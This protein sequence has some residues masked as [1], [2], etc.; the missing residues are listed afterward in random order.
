MNIFFTSDHHFNHANIINYS[1]RPFQSVMDMDEIL[2]ERWNSVVSHKDVVYYVGDLT[3]GNYQFASTVLSMLKGTIVFIEGSHDK[4]LRD[5]DEGYP[6]RSAS[7]TPVKL[8]PPVANINERGKIITLC[9]YAMRSWDRS[10]YGT[11][12]LFGHHHGALEPYGLSFDIG[13]DT[14]NFYPWSLEEVE[15]KMNTLSPIVDYSKGKNGKKE[16]KQGEES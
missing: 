3:L 6:P 13:V 14:H 15:E 1:K 11:W 9:H 12:H 4:W 5:Y 7:G 10:H 2:V 16:N 8:F